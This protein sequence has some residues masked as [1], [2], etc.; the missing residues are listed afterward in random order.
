MRREITI[1][2]VIFRLQTYEQFSAEE[3]VKY[4]ELKEKWEKVNAEYHTNL[5]ARANLQ[6]T[7]KGTPERRDLFHT[8]ELH[9]ELFA[10]ILRDINYELQRLYNERQIYKRIRCC[11]SSLVGN[12][13]EIILNRYIKS[14][15][16]KEV[17]SDFKGSQ[18]TFERVRNSA[19]EK[20]RDR[21]NSF[22][23]DAEIVKSSE[24]GDV[25]L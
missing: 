9:E 16:Y 21:F 3:T 18:R 1:K 13:R 11:Y 20:I 8:L 6:D 7:N 17:L 10:E 2:E 25:D 4:Q 15:P 24:K 23:S 5:Y 14:K 12:E 22:A 19:L